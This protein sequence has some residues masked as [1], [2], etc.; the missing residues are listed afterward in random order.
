MDHG[1]AIIISLIDARKQTYV[2]SAD[3][4]AG[5]K[6]GGEAGGLALQPWIGDSREHSGL[7]LIC[8]VWYVRNALEIDGMFN[9]S[10]P[11]CYILMRSVVILDFAI[12]FTP[13]EICCFVMTAND[14][15]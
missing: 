13:T 1:F 11:K 6:A 3:S 4:E 2:P 8:L 7:I 5:G 15:I 9:F 10:K 14:M 12:Q